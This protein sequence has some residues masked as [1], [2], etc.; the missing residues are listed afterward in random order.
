MCI[1]ITAITINKHTNDWCCFWRHPLTYTVCPTSIVW[2][3]ES[4]KVHW[5]FVI[6]TAR[7]SFVTE[8]IR[9]HCSHDLAYFVTRLFPVPLPS[10]IRTNFAVIDFKI[11]SKFSLEKNAEINQH[12]L[13]NFQD[14]GHVYFL[15]VSKMVQNN[16]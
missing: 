8:Q 10:E 9:Q 12:L 1:Y 15:N 4:S 2:L 3:S 14:Y 7:Q 5:E 6:S 13:L 16:S 11:T